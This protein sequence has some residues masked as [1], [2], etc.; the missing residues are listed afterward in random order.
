MSD[1]IFCKIVTGEIPC[2]KVYEDDN[3]LGFMDIKP[4][5]KGQS[6]LIPKKHYRWVD[7]IPNFGQYFE[8]A[9]KVGMATRE[10]LNP[11]AICYVTLGFEVA[12]AHIR[13]IPRYENDG[14]GGALKFDLFK[15]ITQ[16]ELK[17]TAEKIQAMC[18]N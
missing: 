4:I 3:F 16:E 17:E 14:H 2:Y 7:D 12:H 15:Q 13:I 8:V 18:I 11:L 5:N 10:A 1:C 6:L 9:K